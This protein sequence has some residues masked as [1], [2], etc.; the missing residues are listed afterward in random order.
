[1]QGRGTKIR[2]G[3]PSGPRSL[4]DAFGFDN[5]CVA[6][7]QARR[8]SCKCRIAHSHAVWSLVD[9]PIDA[10][11]ASH[12]EPLRIRFGPVPTAAGRFDS[13]PIAAGELPLGLRGDRFAVEQVAPGI[14]RLPAVPAVWRMPA[15]LADQR[16][17]HRLP[18]LQL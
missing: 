14:A 13:E 18:R 12:Q 11:S 6:L 4:E 9:R 5:P 8:L 10:R 2:A 15:A 16:E 17:A 7:S 3:A 1:M